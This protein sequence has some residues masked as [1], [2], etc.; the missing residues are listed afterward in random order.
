MGRGSSGAVSHLKEA[1]ELGRSRKGRGEGEFRSS[2]QNMSR[3]FPAW[4]CAT[5]SSWE[6]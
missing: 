5:G 6:D 1:M 3:G 2:V 4:C